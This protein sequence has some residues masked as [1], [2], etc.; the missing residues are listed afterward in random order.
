MCN[1]LGQNFRNKPTAPGRVRR[2]GDRNQENVVIDLFRTK[3]VIRPLAATSLFNIL[4]DANYDTAVAY[5]SDRSINAYPVE[6]TVE[7]DIRS[8]KEMSRDTLV[9]NR[10]Y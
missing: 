10:V 4:P 5:I 2:H 6:E 1:L 3:I 7:G 8:S 9:S